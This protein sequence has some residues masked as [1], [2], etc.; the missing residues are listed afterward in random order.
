MKA[1]PSQLVRPVRSSFQAQFTGNIGKP[2][3]FT[4]EFA[5]RKLSR[6][7]QMAAAALG[8]SE[9]ARRQGPE[10]LTNAQ[11]QVVRVPIE[12]AIVAAQIFMAQTSQVDEDRYTFDEL[13][14]F[15]EDDG[16]VEQFYEVVWKLNA[17]DEPQDEL[18]PKA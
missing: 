13:V 17:P 5:V 12:A 16:L 7:E 1:S 9:A 18:A 2:E 11:G 3:A 15:M 14:L 8:T 4:F 6:I 10:F